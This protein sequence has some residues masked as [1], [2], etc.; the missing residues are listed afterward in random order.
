M[1]NAAKTNNITELQRFLMTGA[2]INAKEED[3]TALMWAT[4]NG[5]LEAVQYLVT[6]GAELN[7]KNK[8]GLTALMWAAMNGHLEAVQCLVTAGAELEA[9]DE[10]GCTA[11][12]R[13]ARSGRVAVAQYL[14]YSGNPW[15]SSM[16][17]IPNYD[18]AI[19]ELRKQERST[20]HD[21]KR[22]TLHDLKRSTLHDLN[23]IRANIES[24][25]ATTVLS[26]MG[27]D[28]SAAVIYPARIKLLKARICGVV[29]PEDFTQSLSGMPLVKFNYIVALMRAAKIAN[30]VHGV[31]SYF[32]TRIFMLKSSTSS[33]RTITP[34]TLQAKTQLLSFML[35]KAEA[36]TLMLELQAISAL[37][38]APAAGAAASEDATE[39]E[40]SAAAHPCENSL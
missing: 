38:I 14:V 5:H 12:T 22:S 3:M 36:R 24:L 39:P 31:N 28:A 1:I 13:A 6:A 35:G 23:G 16:R 19:V 33:I 20:L 4:Q 40:H 7:S 11:L 37:A 30:I 17:Q 9:E 32:F 25:K 2:S 15:A 21:L 26:L 8:Y 34:F 27:S 29:F 10:Y 18:A